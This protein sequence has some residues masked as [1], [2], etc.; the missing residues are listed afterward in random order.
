[1]LYKIRAIGY[2]NGRQEE[3]YYLVVADSEGQALERFEEIKP[4]IDPDFDVET[5]LVE[6]YSADYVAIVDESLCAI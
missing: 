5:V 4:Q 6:L 2:I 3:T 1:M